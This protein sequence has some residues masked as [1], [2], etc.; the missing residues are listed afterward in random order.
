MWGSVRAENGGGCDGGINGITSGAQYINGG[1]SCQ[2]RRSCGHAI[3]AQG[4]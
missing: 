4:Y 1:K 3:G 2:R